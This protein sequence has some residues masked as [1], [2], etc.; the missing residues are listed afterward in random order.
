MANR[1]LIPAH[2]GRPSEQPPLSWMKGNDG[3][4]VKC[5]NGHI[6]VLDHD[7]NNQGEVNPSIVCPGRPAVATW[8]ESPCGW[9]VWARLEGWQSLKS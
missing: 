9:H 8:P 2:N 5:P 6:G 7:V 1:V 3:V 4:T